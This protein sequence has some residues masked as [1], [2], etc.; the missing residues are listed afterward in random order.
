LNH[1]LLKHLAAV[2]VG[3][4]DPVVNCPPFVIVDSDD[5]SCLSLHQHSLGELSAAMR[6]GRDRDRG[7][8]RLM[9]LQISQCGGW[10]RTVGEGIEYRTLTEHGYTV[11]MGG[12]QIL[13]S[14]VV[15]G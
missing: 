5:R 9:T 6:F 11:S 15:C 4:G 2:A 3:R 1:R 8:N 13:W 7:Q 10:H 12:T 14:P